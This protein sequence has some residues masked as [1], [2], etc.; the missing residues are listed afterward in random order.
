LLRYFNWNTKT[1]FEVLAQL[2]RIVFSPIKLL[3]LGILGFINEKRGFAFF[4][5]Q[6][7]G[8]KPQVPTAL[9]QL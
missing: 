5:K 8:P 2:H 3:D 6:K 1:T 9:N 4:S 7:K